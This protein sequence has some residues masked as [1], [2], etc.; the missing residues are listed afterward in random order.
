MTPHLVAVYRATSKRARVLVGGSLVAVVAAV[1]LLWPSAQT[2]QL[3]RPDRSRPLGTVAC[4]TEAA[5]AP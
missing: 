2:I 4:F 5:P 3:P 1:L